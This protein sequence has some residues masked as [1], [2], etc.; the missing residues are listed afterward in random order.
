MSKECIHFFGPLCII[1]IL[2]QFFRL[3]Y[4]PGTS[5]QLFVRLFWEQERVYHILLWYSWIRAS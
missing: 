4:Q 5:A 1:I 2:C 3:F